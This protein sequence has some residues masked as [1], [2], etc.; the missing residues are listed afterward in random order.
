M[1]SDWKVFLDWH[2]STADRRCLPSTVLWVKDFYCVRMEQ[3]YACQMLSE[4]SGHKGRRTCRK[5]T[6][7]DGRTPKHIPKKLF[8]GQFIFSWFRKIDENWTDLLVFRVQEICKSHLLKKIR[9]C[10]PESQELIDFKSLK[11]SLNFY[12]ENKKMRDSESCW[13][14]MTR[15]NSF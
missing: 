15:N 5:S 3:I 6:W 4:Y 13:E 2:F 8:V 11:K 10:D 1:Q 7:P 14:S 12:I 9:V